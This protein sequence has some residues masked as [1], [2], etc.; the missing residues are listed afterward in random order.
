M[1]NFFCGKCGFLNS[2][3]NNFCNNCGSKLRISDVDNHFP[4]VDEINY[5]EEEQVANHETTVIEEE[6]IEGIA[7]IEL[8]HKNNDTRNITLFVLLLIGMIVFYN[9]YTTSSPS[10]TSN[11]YTSDNHYHAQTS[12]GETLTTSM[13]D[14]T[15]NKVDVTDYIDVGNEFL[16]LKKEDEIY[17]LTINV[18]FKNV[19]SESR[20]I[21]DGELLINFNGQDYK[22]DKSEIIA[23]NGWGLLLDQINPLTSK[24]TN[25]VFKIPKDL[26][27]KIFWHPGRTDDGETIYLG[28][29]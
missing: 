8:A 23:A 11:S 14:I 29:I 27:G 15:V 13:F 7:P 4:Q 10:K 9:Y 19:D 22:F 2:S 12:V 20:M 1:A 3:E 6:S 5:N 17:Y 26:K 28:E 24:T 16:N 18:T 25:L 21:V